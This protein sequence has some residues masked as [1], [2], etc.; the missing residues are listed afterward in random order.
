MFFLGIRG[1]GGKKGQRGGGGMGLGES[2]VLHQ[3]L[4]VKWQKDDKKK[5]KTI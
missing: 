3:S 4:F 2:T 5:K 1:E